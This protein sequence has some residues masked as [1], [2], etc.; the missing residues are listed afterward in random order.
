MRK[1]AE[2][3]R[4]I[5]WA[6]CPLVVVTAPACPCGS[7]EY[8][9]QRSE[10][11]GDGTTTRKAICRECGHPFKIAIELPYFGNQDDQGL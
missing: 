7:L 11:N 6:D 1:S 10:A 3:S 9:T 8:T 2:K 5:N 4:R